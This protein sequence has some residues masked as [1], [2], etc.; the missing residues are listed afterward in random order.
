VRPM[1]P[2]PLAVTTVLATHCPYKY[3][4]P[5]KGQD[6]ERTELHPPACEKVSRL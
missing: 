6:E 4:Q 2:G 5:K 1:F 3:F